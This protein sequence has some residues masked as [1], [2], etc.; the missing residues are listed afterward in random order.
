MAGRKSPAARRSWYRW[1]V[2]ASG[3]LGGCY[4]YGYAPESPVPGTSLAVDLNDAG[5]AQLE[6]NVGPEVATV[7]GTLA[8]VTD[9]A[10]TLQVARTRTLRGSV[11]PWAGESV[12]LRTGQYRL[13][14]ERRFSTPRT[15]V[16]VGSLTAG[17]VSFAASRGLLGL[18]AGGGT[19]G[20]TPPPN[21]Q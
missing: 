16:L 15:V 7:E 9:S 12:T 6:N 2:L 18:G 11:Q 3:L 17:F 8:S 1:M 13:V 10:M 19:G 21:N 4:T 5:R 14:R 20:E